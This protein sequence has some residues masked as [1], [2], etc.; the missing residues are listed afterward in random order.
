MRE[1]LLYREDI[2]VE[3]SPNWEVTIIWGL[4]LTLGIS[5]SVYV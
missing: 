3:R 2:V 1:E 4:I 5:F